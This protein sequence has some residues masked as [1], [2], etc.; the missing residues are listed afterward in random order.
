MNEKVKNYLG[1]AIIIAIL[2]AAGAGVWYAASFAKTAEIPGS[3]SFE[4]T[5]QGKVVAIPDVAQF[6]FGVITDGDK[7]LGNLQKEN[8][9][10]TNKVIDFLKAQGVE[11]KDLKTTNYSVDPRYQYYSCPPV[12]SEGAESLRYPVPSPCPPADIMGYIITQTVSVKIRDFDKVGEILGGV[13]ERGANSVSQLSFTVDDRTKYEDE[14]RAEALDKARKKAAVM[15]QAGGFKLGKLLSIFDS[16][17]PPTPYYGEFGGGFAAPAKADA[18]PV[19]EPGSSEISVNITLRY[20][21]K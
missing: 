13:T 8:T 18:A 2:G 4:V 11:P 1:V 20:E 12:I 10:K 21:I 9:E 6:S 17:Y 5:G 14:A 15:A 7:K 3:R 19:I 16:Y